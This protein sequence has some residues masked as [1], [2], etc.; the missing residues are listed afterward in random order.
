MA[1][2]HESFAKSLYF[3]IHNKLKSSFTKSNSGVISLF[4]FYIRIFA[5]LSTLSSIYF[6]FI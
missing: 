4:M 5:K 6:Y 2:Q 1:L 3:V